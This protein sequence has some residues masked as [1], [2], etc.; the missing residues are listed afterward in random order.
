MDFL[1]HLKKIREKKQKTEDRKNEHDLFIDDFIKSL[2]ENVELLSSGYVCS[3]DIE[4]D[5]TPE[6]FSLDENNL[7]E[8]I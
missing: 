8:E 6:N 2:G 3:D 4:E 5:D 7:K 1:D